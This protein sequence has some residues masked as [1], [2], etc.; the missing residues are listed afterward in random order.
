M[1][2]DIIGALEIFNRY[3]QHH[4]HIEGDHIFAGCST[5][6]YTEDEQDTLMEC[7]WYTTSETWCKKL[8]IC[9]ETA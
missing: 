8:D 2:N 1:S 7:G 6:R 5:F 9:T 4:F 3:G